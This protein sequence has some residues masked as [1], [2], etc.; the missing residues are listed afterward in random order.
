VDPILSN[1]LVI[2]RVVVLT[3]TADVQHLV[4]PPRPLKG[5]H[6]KRSKRHTLLT[7]LSCGIYGVL[8]KHAVCSYVE[9]G[10]QCPLEKHCIMLVSLTSSDLSARIMWSDICVLNPSEYLT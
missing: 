4:R 6:I 8:H 1:V 10:L 2:P 5:F 9:V 3:C 7:V